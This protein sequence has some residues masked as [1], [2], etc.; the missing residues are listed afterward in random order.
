MST[1]YLNDLKK[2]FQSN[3]LVKLFC[4]RLQT[5]ISYLIITTYSYNCGQITYPFV[6]RV[7]STQKRITI[8]CVRHYSS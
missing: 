6:F 7:I 8:I 1:L 4:C 3:V 5:K 2:K